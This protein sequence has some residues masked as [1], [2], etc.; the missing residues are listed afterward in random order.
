[1]ASGSLLKSEIITEESGE[2]IELLTQV[3]H[4]LVGTVQGQTLALRLVETARI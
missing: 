3:I 2:R 1:M 4:E